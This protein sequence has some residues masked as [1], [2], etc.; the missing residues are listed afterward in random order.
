MRTLVLHPGALTRAFLEGQRVR[1]VAPINLYLVF[2]GLFFF[3]HTLRPF[4]AYHPGTNALRSNLSAVSVGASLSVEQLAR[5]QA[6]GLGPLRPDAPP[7][8]WG[9]RAG[10]PVRL[11][12]GRS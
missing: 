8:A 7:P 6:A 11:P 2:S 3:L 5:M 4:V 12:G 9:G 10:R 1:Y